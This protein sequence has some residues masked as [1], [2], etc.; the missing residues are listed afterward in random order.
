MAGP[1][2]P[3]NIWT[4]SGV[5]LVEMSEKSPRVL[6]SRSANLGRDRTKRLRHRATTELRAAADLPKVRDRS[7]EKTVPTRQAGLYN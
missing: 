4:V 7:F 2:A 6:L 3:L 1:S 5:L